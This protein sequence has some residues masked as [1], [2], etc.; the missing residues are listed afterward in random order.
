[1]ATVS[2]KELSDHLHEA[3]KHVYAAMASDDEQPELK[4]EQVRNSLRD[5]LK[6]F[7]PAEPTGD[8]KRFQTEHRADDVFRIQ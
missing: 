4:F 7:D 3:C 1:M 6:L 5:A 2:L 8:A